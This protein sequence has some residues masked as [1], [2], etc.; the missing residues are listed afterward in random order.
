MAVFLAKNRLNKME[1]PDPTRH[2]TTEMS[3]ITI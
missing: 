1:S 3:P 2:K